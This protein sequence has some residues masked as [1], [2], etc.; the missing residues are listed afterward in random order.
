MREDEHRTIL[1]AGQHTWHLCAVWT[2]PVF[3]KQKPI[4]RDAFIEHF[5]K[6]LVLLNA[7][8]D[9]VDET[10]INPAWFPA[11]LQHGVTATNSAR[12]RALQRT[13]KTTRRVAR[14]ASRNL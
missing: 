2:C 3:Y 11:Q 13:R 1:S 9:S 4:T 10:R 12:C 14:Q 8:L 6:E 7:I 5:Q